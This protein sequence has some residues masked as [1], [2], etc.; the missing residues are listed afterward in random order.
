MA[1]NNSKT[2]F[3]SKFFSIDQV[4]VEHKG[5]QF[6]K[7]II[8]RR[9]VVLILPLNEHNELYLVSQYRDALKK[10]ALEIV[11]GQMDEGEDPAE[12]AKRE[13]HEETGLQAGNL[14]HL[15][16]WQQSANMVGK[17][18]LFLATDLTEGEAAPD[19]DEDIETVRIPLDEVME[20]VQTGE[21]DIVSNV[22]SLLLLDK[23]KK[24]GK[25]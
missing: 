16:T 20:K 11:A 24:E 4:E 17:N 5:K 19:D 18:H 10:V 3:Q 13:L 14:K 2:V 22:A 9:D 23:L 6:T 12:A 21:I 25:V 7:D 15:V 1:D 8:V